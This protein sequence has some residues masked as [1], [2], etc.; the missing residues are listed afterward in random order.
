MC[1]S[2][3]PWSVLLSLSLSL[4]TTTLVSCFFYFFLPVLWKHC[5]T[6][7]KARTPARVCV[8]VCSLWFAMEQGVEGERPAA[9]LLYHPISPPPSISIHSHQRGAWL[10]GAL[11]LPPS[12]PSSMKSNMGPRWGKARSAAEREPRRRK[13]SF[14]DK[15]EFWRRGHVPEVR[16]CQRDRGVLIWA[17]W[18]LTSFPGQEELGRER[19]EILFFF[20]LIRARFSS[21]GVSMCK[22]TWG[23]DGADVPHVHI[24]GRV[25]FYVWLFIQIDLWCNSWVRD[26]HRNVW[27]QKS[28]HL[29]VVMLALENE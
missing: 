24:R 22:Q 23:S 29:P 21:R 12:S 9:V 26:V 11:V 15:N 6:Q 10:R 4:L 25:V 28:R 1:K 7:F 13:K 20:F 19:T 16:T 8:C 5:S 2:N 27:K 18:P 3:S 14:L 17:W